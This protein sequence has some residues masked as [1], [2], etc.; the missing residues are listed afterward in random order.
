M[1]KR[2]VNPRDLPQNAKPCKSLTAYADW[3]KR[4]DFCQ[5]CG[6]SIEAASLQIQGLTRHHMVRTGRAHEGCNLL[7]LCHRDHDL[8]EG[9]TIRERGAVLPKLTL[10]RCLTLKRY[11]ELSEWNPDRLRELRL[12]N[13][14]DLE[15]VPAFLER[16]FRSRV[17]DKSLWL[18]DRMVMAEDT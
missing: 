18:P 5:A 4:H 12:S 14:P 8:A 7:M 3:A 2:L 16:E 13:L 6:L 9:L 15:P 17:P 10:G 11:R 1:A